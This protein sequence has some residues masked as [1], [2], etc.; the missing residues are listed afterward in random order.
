MSTKRLLV[1]FTT[2]FIFWM[3]A[4]TIF[5]HKA[6]GTTNRSPP[7]P[8]R[9]ELLNLAENYADEMREMNLSSCG[10]Y[11]A[12]TR[13]SVGEI[14]FFIFITNTRYEGTE[15]IIRITRVKT[16]PERLN[17]VYDDETRP[18]VIVEGSPERRYFHLVL[19]K[20]EY[21]KSPCLTSSIRT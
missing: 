20:G 4:V 19:S 12:V 8:E 14:I 18:S 21:L 2:F 10:N 13:D 1:F 6:H 9:Y 17:F 3:L 16:E 15:K 11:F 5:S 7:P